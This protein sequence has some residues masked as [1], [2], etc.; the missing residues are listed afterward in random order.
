MIKPSSSIL[1]KYNTIK[2]GDAFASCHIVKEFCDFHSCLKVSFIFLSPWFKV[3]IGFVLLQIGS[4]TQ[5]CQYLFDR[6]ADLC[7]WRVPV[8]P[9]IQVPN[10][11]VGA[12]TSTD[13]TLECYV[14]ASPKSINYWVRDSGKVID[15]TKT[16]KLD[17]KLEYSYVRDTIT[18]FM[19]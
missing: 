17:L 12:P 9:V 18:W 2:L 16:F 7:S 15:N 8:H 19:K 1:K 4:Y 5:V 13:V 6:S 11:L 3:W 10:Q 14:E